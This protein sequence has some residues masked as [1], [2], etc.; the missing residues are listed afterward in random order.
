MSS[1]APDWEQIVRLYD[2]LQRLQPCPIVSLNRAV[3]FAMAR[4]LQA[5]LAIIDALAE[6]SDP[7]DYQL[8][9][10]AHADLLR[11][12]GATE[13]AAEAYGR[14]LALATNE[15]ERASSSAGCTQCKR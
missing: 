4:G 5:G 6:A 15:S 1:T 2:L 13:Q 11:R 14:A 10:S 9:H 12:M 3:A 8:L 7:D